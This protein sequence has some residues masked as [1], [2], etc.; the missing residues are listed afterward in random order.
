MGF[1]DHSNHLKRLD[2]V[3][4]QTAKWWHKS[5]FHFLNVNVV[6]D[7]IIFKMLDDH[8]GSIKNVKEF[9]LSAIEG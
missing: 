8:N 9:H 7:N 6:N 4:E 3:D 5:F 2:E 1:V